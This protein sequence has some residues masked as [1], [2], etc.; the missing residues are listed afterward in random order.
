MT[1][2]ARFIALASFACLFATAVMARDSLGMFGSWGAFRDP[3]IPRCYA[4]SLPD[5]ARGKSSGSE[6]GTY[7]DVA[8]WPKRDVRNQVHFHLARHLAANGA[9]T[10]SLGGQHFKLAGGGSDVWAA[11]RRMD[12]AIVAAM[13]S[14]PNMTLTAHDAANRLLVY[15]WELSGSASAMDSAALGCAELR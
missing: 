4:I 15:A 3:A 8:S 14:A 7:A 11:D 10:L 12:A 2:S 13:R 6:T 9:I 1:S 5:A